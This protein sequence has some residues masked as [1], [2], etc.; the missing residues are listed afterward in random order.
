MTITAMYEAASLYSKPLLADLKEKGVKIIMFS[1]DVPED[2][3]K[4]CDIVYRYGRVEDRFI[5][6]FSLQY[7]GY[8]LSDMIK[9]S[10]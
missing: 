10:R 5:G 7:L 4:I 3:E 9:N 1:Q 2:I 6:N 8:V